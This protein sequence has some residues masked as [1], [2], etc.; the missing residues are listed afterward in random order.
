MEKK[1][2]KAKNDFVNLLYG[3]GYLT[4]DEHSCLLTGTAYSGKRYIEVVY[5]GIAWFKDSEMSLP[6]L[7]ITKIADRVL[8]S[9]IENG[10]AVD[11]SWG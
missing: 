2:L 11:S 3:K 8:I 4:D 6:F 5:L 7:K 10:I 1:N 9:V